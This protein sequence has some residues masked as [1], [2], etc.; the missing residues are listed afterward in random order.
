M[1][2]Q[3]HVICLPGLVQLSHLQ[4]IEDPLPHG[5]PSLPFAG[6]GQ[7]ASRGHLSGPPLAPGALQA[8][9]AA[10]LQLGFNEL[11]HQHLAEKWGFSPSFSLGHK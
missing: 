6:A 3:A 1:D 2:S 5:L 7:R 8:G 10:P 9:P 11:S 4:A